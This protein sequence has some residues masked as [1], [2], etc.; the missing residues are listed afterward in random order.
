MR[1][2]HSCKDF[3]AEALAIAVDFMYGIPIPENFKEGGELLRLADLLM[4]ETLKLEAGDILVGNLTT[5]NYLEASR[6]V[7]IYC[8][9]NLMTSCA[10]FVFEN[11]DSMD[12][13]WEEMEKLPKVMSALVKIAKVKEVKEVDWEEMEKFP[14][15]MSAIVKI[16][17]SQS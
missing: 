15:F 5:E 14:K 4:M 12:V 2:I 7:E 3:T 17:K 8:E 16:R 10:K 9:E 6:A 11:V 1:N 13:N